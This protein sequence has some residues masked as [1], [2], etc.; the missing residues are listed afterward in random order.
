MPITYALDLERHEREESRL[1][2]ASHHCIV[3]TGALR[4]QRT[5]HFAIVHRDGRHAL[6]RFDAR[7]GDSVNGT[8][9]FLLS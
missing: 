6:G 7:L 5:E 2:L 9:V 8:H 1:V 3:E 4:R